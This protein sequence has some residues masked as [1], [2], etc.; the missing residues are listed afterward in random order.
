[1]AIL[2][3]ATQATGSDADVAAASRIDAAI[4]DLAVGTRVADDG[5]VTDALSTTG[6]R[7]FVPVTVGATRACGAR[8]GSPATT[9]FG[10][11]LELVVVVAG[12]AD[13]AQRH[14]RMAAALHVGRT[15]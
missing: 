10:T 1:M 4:E 13:R 3:V 9:A 5:R 6:H 12:A 15:V 7:V 11:T 14:A 8:A 2:I